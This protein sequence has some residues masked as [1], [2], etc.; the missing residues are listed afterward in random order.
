MTEYKQEI[1]PLAFKQAKAIKDKIAELKI[2]DNMS[3]KEVDQLVIE[4]AKTN[5]EGTGKPFKKYLSGQ[6]WYVKSLIEKSKLSDRELL[7][8]Q[9]K[10]LLPANSSFDELVNMMAS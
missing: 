5:A 8:A 9:Y 2:S 10:E 7:E 3:E 4:L 6:E 1:L